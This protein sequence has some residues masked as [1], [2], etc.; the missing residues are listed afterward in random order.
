MEAGESGV[1]ELHI[2]MKF[3]PIYATLDPVS[4]S[5]EVDREKMMEDEN[6][7]T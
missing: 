6:K 2:Y 7:S 5:Q 3:R 4:K 1:T